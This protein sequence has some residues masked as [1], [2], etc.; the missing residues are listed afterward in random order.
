MVSG[1]DENAFD[2]VDS[3]PSDVSILQ[4]DGTD[5]HSERVARMLFAEAVIARAMVRLMESRGRRA[6]EDLAY[7]EKFRMS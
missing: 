2:L 5:T 4:L 1:E 3:A 6:V 7:V